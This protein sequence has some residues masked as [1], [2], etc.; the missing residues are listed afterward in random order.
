[1][2]L[3]T[4]CS[5]LSLGWKKFTQEFAISKHQFL[6]KIKIGF[7]AQLQET[8]LKVAI[9]FG[10]WLCCSVPYLLIC[11]CKCRI[12]CL[13]CLGFLFVSFGLFLFVWFDLVWFSSYNPYFSQGKV[14]WAFPDVG[15]FSRPP[16]QWD[17]TPQ[18]WILG[19][20]FFNFILYD[21]YEITKSFIIVLQIYN[22][23]TPIPL[24][25]SNSLLQCSS[26]ICLP[27]VCFCKRYFMYM[28]FEVYR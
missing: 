25:V 16:S 3:N 4:L 14:T 20:F 21:Y 12:V 19:C 2:P 23:S 8:T 10:P 9:D 27:L 15:H 11:Y 26:P 5:D 13:K 1:M 18:L 6:R 22:A 7:Q 28:F 24:P 17:C